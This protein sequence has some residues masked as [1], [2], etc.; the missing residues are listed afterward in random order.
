[1]KPL[2]AT[3]AAAAALAPSAAL[4]LDAGLSGP[5]QTLC[6]ATDGRPA[7]VHAQA[8]GTGYVTPP[9]MMMRAMV[10][11][12]PTMLDP[13]A[14]WKVYDGG[15]VMVL[16]GRM[17]IPGAAGADGDVCMVMDLPGEADPEPQL[18]A[19][20]GTGA[21]VKTKDIDLFVYEIQHDGGRRA[22]DPADAGNFHRLMDQGRLRLAAT[23]SEAKNGDRIA[24]M[25]LLIPRAPGAAN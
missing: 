17:A 11:S 10:S 21:P 24:M 6:L 7:A 23:L 12:M 9:N 18:G 15:L 1:M 16:T 3:I 19:L 8:R 20:L 4:A 14:T 13:V 22:I 2:L 25:F 5:F